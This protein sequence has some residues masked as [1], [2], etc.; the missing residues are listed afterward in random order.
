MDDVDALTIEQ[1]VDVPTIEQSRLSD[2]C[3]C[4]LKNLQMKT[5]FL[6][7]R[8]TD[9]IRTWV[10]FECA[11][12]SN[13]IAVGMEQLLGVVID[14]AMLIPPRSVDLISKSY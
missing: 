10:S 8:E 14:A 12:R 13:G 6:V 1:N 7:S 9:F 3:N 4:G 2:N 11:T 5:K